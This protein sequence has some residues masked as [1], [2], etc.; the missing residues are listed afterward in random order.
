MAKDRKMK[1]IQNIG[2]QTLRYIL[3]CDSYILGLFIPWHI[4]MSLGSLY[5]GP[6][7][8]VCSQNI[9][10]DTKICS[11]GKDIAAKGWEIQ[12]STENKNQNLRFLVFCRLLPISTSAKIDKPA[13]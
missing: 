4:L 2:I 6:L 3:V 8:F 9:P 13:A 12:K 10:R 1:S 11:G 7:F 5:F